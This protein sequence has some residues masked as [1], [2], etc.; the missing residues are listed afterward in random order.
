MIELCDIQRCVCYSTPNTMSNSIVCVCMCSLQKLEE[1]KKEETRQDLVMMIA[2]TLN[3]M[4]SRRDNCQDMPGGP[5]RE[6]CSPDIYYTLLLS[7]T[8]SMYVWKQG[9]KYGFFSTFR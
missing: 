1:L 2:A 8:G 3:H 7:F 5:R 6:Y 9:W 4:T